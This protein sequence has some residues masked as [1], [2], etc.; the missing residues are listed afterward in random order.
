MKLGLLDVAKRHQAILLGAGAATAVGA[1]V[2]RVP[3]LVGM[4]AGNTLVGIGVNV[5]A[6]GVLLMIGS[7]VKP[8]A[9][10]G[11]SGVFL[12]RAVK[13]VFPKIGTLGA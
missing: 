7:K 4:S 6:A 11:A 2:D 13:G 12:G 8:T 3:P 9:M 1:V 5:L 10:A